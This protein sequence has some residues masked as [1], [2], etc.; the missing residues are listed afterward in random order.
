MEMTIHTFELTAILSVEETEKL[1]STLFDYA[2]GKQG[3]CYKNGNRLYFNRWCSDGI[4]FFLHRN[5]NIPGSTLHLVITPAKI[6]G[7]D[8][9]AALFFPSLQN[10]DKIDAVIR[11]ILSLLP[12][13]LHSQQMQLNRLD[14]CRNV[15]LPEQ[16]YID[17]YI[18]LLKKGAFAARW[19]KQSYPDGDER[20]A[21]SFRMVN[22]YYQV[23]VYDKLYQIKHEG[24][25]TNW[26]KSDRILR[27]EVSLLRPGILEELERYMLYKDASWSSQLFDL[28]ANGGSIMYRIICRLV[29]DA[30][31]YTLS[32]AKKYLAAQD[33]SYAKKTHLI[34]FLSEINQSKLFDKERIKRKFSNA[35]KRFKQLKSLQI[36]PAT[37]EVRA[38]I[39]YLPSLNQLISM[40]FTLSQLNPLFKF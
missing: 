23:T 13:K 4:R 1:R 20:N 30:P 36:N 32:A 6:L 25:H 40:E 16:R 38:G 21:H 11:E 22:T 10:M 33:I 27:V 18:H 15:L 12:I 34:A 7:Y 26:E 31:Y 5:T 9:A 3:M 37:I 29:S 2:K 17:T 8:D 14:L 19:E 39:S 28:A 24:Y 35:K